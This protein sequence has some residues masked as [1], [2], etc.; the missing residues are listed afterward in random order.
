MHECYIG[1]AIFRIVRVYL[2]ADIGSRSRR[3]NLTGGNRFQKPHR[4]RAI[5]N[6]VGAGAHKESPM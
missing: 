4:E 6:T 3:I 1:K 2:C 5:S